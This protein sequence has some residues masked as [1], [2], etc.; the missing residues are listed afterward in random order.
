MLCDTTGPAAF[1]EKVDKKNGIFAASCPHTPNTTPHGCAQ[2]IASL[3]LACPYIIVV[4][5]ASRFAF[6]P[7][8]CP[9]AHPYLGGSA[10]SPKPRPGSGPE[11]RFVSGPKLPTSK[12]K[13]GA[14]RRAKQRICA[15]P[16]VSHGAPGPLLVELH[17]HLLQ[18]HTCFN[19]IR[20]LPKIALER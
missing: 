18:N 4:A 11:P 5:G 13:G 1:S 7:C 15:P 19:H 2:K 17:A 14:Q 9:C 16:R 3:P 20:S 10:L 12:I 8:P 6:A